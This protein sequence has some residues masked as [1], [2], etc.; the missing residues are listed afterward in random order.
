MNNLRILMHWAKIC[1]KTVDQAWA[2]SSCGVSYLS[3]I[4][5]SSYSPKSSSNSALVILLKSTLSLVRDSNLSL[6]A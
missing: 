5:S 2:Y 6:M 1:I 3:F 4:N